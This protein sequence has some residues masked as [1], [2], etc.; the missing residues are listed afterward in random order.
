MACDRYF[1]AAY[2]SAIER[3]IFSVPIPA[4]ISSTESNVE[5]KA[6]SDSSN[7]SFYST[8]FSP[9]AGFYLMSYEGPNIPWQRIVQTD[10]A[11][12]SG[13]IPYFKLCCSTSNIFEC[14]S[15]SQNSTMS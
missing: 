11:S 15:S 13:L 2:P 4:T 12:E 7:P 6:L 1:L 14:E 5:P 10:N 3:N 9:E 8:S